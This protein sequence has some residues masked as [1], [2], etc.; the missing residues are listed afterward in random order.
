MP[1]RKITLNLWGGEVPVTDVPIVKK[2]E[3]LAEYELEDGSTIR[4][5]S[6]VTQVL[7]VDGQYDP[8]GQPFYLVKTGNVVN[9]ISSQPHLRRK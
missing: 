6:V 7:R 2:S 4:V 9:T 5:A 3:S 1:E 8:E